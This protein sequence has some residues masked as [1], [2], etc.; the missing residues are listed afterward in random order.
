[1]TWT[2]SGGA[3]KPQELIKG[4]GTIIVGALIEKQLR[5]S[6]IRDWR[7]DSLAVTLEIWPG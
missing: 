4:F 5:G 3:P 2:E 1:M 6:I 7:D